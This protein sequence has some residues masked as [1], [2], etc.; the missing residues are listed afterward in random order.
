MH[1]RVLAGPGTGKSYT[2]VRYLEHLADEHPDISARMLTFTRAA[3]AEFAEQMGDANLEGL[4]VARPA[5]VHSYALSLLMRMDGVNL[6]MP[7]R[8]PDSW[9]IKRLIRPHLSRLL[10]AAGHAQA[11]ST[12]LRSL[13]L[14]MSAGWESLDPERELY[15]D[16]DPAL[17]AAYAGLWGQH[18]WVFGY[19]LLAELPLRAGQAL[20]DLGNESV[21]LDLLLVDEYQDLNEAD[22]KLIRLVTGAGVAV[23]AIGDDDQS[24]YGFRQAAPEGT[25]RFLEEFNTNCDYPLTES[26]RCGGAILD[27]ARCLIESAPRRPAKISLTPSADAPA[28]AYAYLRFP[29][30]VAE[31]KGAARIIA[32]RVAAGVPAR[33]IGVLVRSAE[34]HWTSVLE[35]ELAALGVPLSSTKWVEEAL[36]EAE[37]RRGI[38]LG[39]L[40]LERTDSLA[41]WGL[42]ELAR[43][44]GPTFI[45][46]VYDQRAGRETF[47]DALLRLHH[48]GF[49][50]APGRGA[51]IA[52]KIIDE[53]LAIIDEL[54]VEAAALDERGWGGWLVDQ[55]DSS[56]L[57]VHAVQLFE[58]VG[59]AVSPDEGIHGLLANLEPLGKDLAANEADGVRMMTIGRSKGRTLNTAIVLGVEQ[60]VIPLDKPDVDDAEERRLLYVAM[61]RAT[62]MCVLTYAKQRTGPSARIGSPRVGRARNRSPLLAG[63][64]GRVGQ[65]TD[66]SAFV[67]ALEAEGGR[68]VTD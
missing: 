41:W 66:G 25:L 6:P 19:V 16:R 2:S 12:I 54:V 50:G 64:P 49:G 35:P 48:G 51:E 20:E 52:A 33:E 1:G 28:G 24:I 4:G 40:A 56:A 62:D 9:E 27:A 22:I 68:C 10:R 31:V 29:G 26:R 46:H 21:E 5:T 37:V 18:R 45:D 65:V 57:S 44:V 42:L 58:M 39:H 32:A 13:E 14:E 30:H 63:L 34:D 67:R 47:G 61:T 7:L 36:D 11:T 60:G 38:A 43:G 15:V 17:G 55:L 23:L 3:T 59:S 8:I 53:T